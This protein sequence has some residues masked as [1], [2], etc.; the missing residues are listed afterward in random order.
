MPDSYS[1]ADAARLLGVSERRVL[2]L[3][4]EGRLPAERTAAAASACRRP[5][6]M[7]PGETVE[8]LSAAPPETSSMWRLWRPRWRP[9]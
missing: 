6:F 1:A 7:Q 4:A 9:P 8:A 2:Q 5:L 3:I